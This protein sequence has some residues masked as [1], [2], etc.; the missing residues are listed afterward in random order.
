[1]QKSLDRKLAA[2]AAN[3]QCGEF[4]L[5]DA[6]DADMAFG[7]SSPGKNV[8]ATRPR[9]IVEY[10]DIIRQ[11][12]R[13]GLVDIVLMSASN[14]EILTIEERLFDHSPVTPAARGNDASDV[15]AVRG[16]RYVTE[17]AAP[18]RSASLDHIM[19]GRIDCPDSERSRGSDL[20]LY[21]V[22]FTNHL[23]RDLK[24][25]ET[26]REF[27]HEA[28]RK[29][30]RHFLEVFDPNVD[31]GLSPEEIPPFINDMIVRTLA[32]VTKKGRP[33][34]LKIVYHGPESMEELVA[35]DPSLVVGILGGS[36]GT[37][38][39]AFKMLAEAK[40]YG[41]KAALYGRKINASEQPLAF[42]H[43]LRLIADGQISAEEAVRG[44]HG[45]LQ[46]LGIPPHRS[47]EEDMML[48]T[49]V[50][51]YAGNGTT[52]SIPGLTP[53]GRPASPSSPS[54]SPR[55]TTSSSSTAPNGASNGVSANGD[56]PN[57][58]SMN[59]EERLAYHRQRIARLMGEGSS[60]TVNAFARTGD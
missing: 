24:T 46:Q 1:M 50:M 40:K 18:F 32:G 28:E 30:F 14:N 15:F 21:S 35:Y 60:V 59:S 7:I 42:I 6:K 19:A 51:S 3:P 16:G 27:R 20:G 12:I 39:D 49:G 8:G 13:Q 37:T 48:R 58:G 44:Y 54:S 47:L 57:F 26:Y 2:I 45:V 36:A 41:A 43:F 33:V 17:P 10:R 11:V 4:I 52:T 34:F 5:A 31:C 9:N 55:V 23:E 29:G 22:T 38:Y 56:S 25:L 53:G